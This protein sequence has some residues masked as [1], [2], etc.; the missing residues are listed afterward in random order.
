MHLQREFESRALKK[1]SA[2]LLRAVS[3]LLLRLQEY[4]NK[5]DLS[6]A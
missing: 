2:R 1:L 3:M 5:F 6:P 4:Y